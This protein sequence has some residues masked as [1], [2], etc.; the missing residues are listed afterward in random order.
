MLLNK[1]EVQRHV[2]D[3]FYKV[4]I[5]GGN[6]LP[7]FNVGVRLTKN[8]GRLELLSEAVS[9]FWSG[10]WQIASEASQKFSPPPCRGV[11]SFTGGWQQLI[12]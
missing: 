6:P 4:Q 2:Q 1:K 3:F 9:A 10:G 8:P 12:H 5:K 7:K 11:A